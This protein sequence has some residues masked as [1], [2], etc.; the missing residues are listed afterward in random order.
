MTTQKWHI[1]RLEHDRTELERPEGGQ[2]ARADIGPDGAF[3]METPGE[4]RG[5]IVGLNKV[6]VACYEGQRDGYATADPLAEP[7]LG[8]LL[9]PRRYTSFHT[10]GLEVE[11]RPGRNEPIVFELTDP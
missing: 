9:I 11:V 4:G 7:S 6:R 5:A 2:P 8:K 1:F 3:T 10:S